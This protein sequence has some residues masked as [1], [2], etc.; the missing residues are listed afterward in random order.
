MK[1]V[2]IYSE[3]QTE[4]V[5]I[6]R[7]LRPYL[8]QNDVFAVSTLTQSNKNRQHKGGVLSYAKTVREIQNLCKEHKHETVS[9]MIDLYALPSDFPYGDTGDL[10]SD[11]ERLEEQIK[12]SVGEPN[13]IPYVSVHEFEALLFSEPEAFA[14]INEEAAET[15]KAIAAEY[16]NPEHINNSPETAPSKRILAAIEEYSK[17]G[18][19]IT[20]ASKIGIHKMIE[21]CPHFAQWV[22]KLSQ[23]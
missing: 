7:L 17:V 14:C 23:I 20:I 19:G 1:N 5:F 12:L 18:D 2:Y 22:K 8:L 15:L 9:S 3:G 11:V 6:N 16:N 4:Y 13:F 10:Y 21:R